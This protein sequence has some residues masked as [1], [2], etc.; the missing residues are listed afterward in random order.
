V[1]AVGVLVG[2]HELEH[3]VLVDARRQRQLH[4]VARD[5]VARIELRDRRDDVGC[6]CIGRQVDADRLDPH[7]GAVAVL[8]RDV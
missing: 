2:I 7:L 4:D 3:R 1:Q 5:V 6:G 8:A